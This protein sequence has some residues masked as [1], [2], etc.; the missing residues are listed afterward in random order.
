MLSSIRAD[1]YKLAR[2]SALHSNKASMGTESK[3]SSSCKTINKIK[4]RGGGEII[5]INIFDV[6]KCSE[7]V[8]QK[9]PLQS[10]VN[11]I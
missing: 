3:I 8:L 4:K 10:K 5:Q 11:D 1:L 7:R 2:D 9:T 6:K